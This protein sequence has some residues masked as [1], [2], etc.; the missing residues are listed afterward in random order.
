MTGI[1]LYLFLGSSLQLRI[2]YETHSCCCMQCAFSLLSLVR[3]YHDLLVS[4][5]VNGH[6]SVSMFW[7]YKQCC[8]RQFCTYFLVYICKNFSTISILHICKYVYL[9]ILQPMPNSLQ[10]ECILPKQCCFSL[11]VKII[12]S[13]RFFLPL[14]DYKH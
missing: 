12:I 8:H 1:M 5:L 3:L 6:F 14:P 11:C 10:N 9:Q 2:V 7:Q 13:L 4:F